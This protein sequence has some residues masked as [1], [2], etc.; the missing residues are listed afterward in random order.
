M[1]DSS[2]G[3]H[4]VLRWVNLQ[5]VTRQ[6]YGGVCHGSPRCPNKHDDAAHDQHQPG[7]DGRPQEDE[8]HFGAPHRNAASPATPANTPTNHLKMEPP[9][10]PAV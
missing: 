4:G 10:L 1:F 9:T 2:G 5:R 8:A 3:N 6:R 7:D